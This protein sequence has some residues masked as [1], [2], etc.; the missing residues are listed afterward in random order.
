MFSLV[1]YMIFYSRYQGDHTVDAVVDWMATHILGLPR[2][3]YYTKETL[4]NHAFSSW[5]C[6]F[7]WLFL[8]IMHMHILERLVMIFMV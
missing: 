4:V 8:F 1:L 7:Q 5:I 3:L 6:W 2:I